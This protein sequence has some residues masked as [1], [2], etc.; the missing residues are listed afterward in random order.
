MLVAAL[1]RS[2]SIFSTAIR[3]AKGFSLTDRTSF[4]RAI[5]H[6]RIE[7][8]IG[9]FFARVPTNADAYIRRS[10]IHDWPD[11]QAI[12]ILKDVRAATKPDSR[13]FLIEE[14]IPEISGFAS[15]MG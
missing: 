4:A 3:R 2:W 5:P 11:A 7:R 10:V 12:T 8:V 6:D 1:A 14:I 9:S 15:S 13:V